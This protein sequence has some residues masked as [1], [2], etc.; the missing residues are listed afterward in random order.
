[1]KQVK[2]S[3][4]LTLPPTLDDSG[5]FFSCAKTE[6]I[7]PS[8]FTPIMP[9]AKFFFA[10]VPL[11]LCSCSCKEPLVDSSSSSATKMHAVQLIEFP[12]R[13]T[14]YYWEFACQF[15]AG[16]KI[17]LEKQVCIPC[18]SI[19]GG[20][21]GTFMLGAFSILVYFW[22]WHVYGLTF[23]THLIFINIDW[24]ISN[25]LFMAKF[26]SF[27]ARKLPFLAS[28]LDLG[29]SLFFTISV[30]KSTIIFA[31]VLPVSKQKIQNCNVCLIVFLF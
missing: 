31:V 21:E 4:C 20:A 6:A 11:Y 17:Y 14:Y 13:V 18:Q 29:N 7:S 15:F 2:N 22:H 27:P 26:F 30:T 3:H 8:Y 16:K 25:L 28:I 12:P 1:M 9:S 10:L 5:T 23:N 24:S 19:F